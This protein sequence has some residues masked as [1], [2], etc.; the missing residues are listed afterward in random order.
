M[1]LMHIIVLAVIQGLTEFLPISSTAHLV[2]IPYFAN[3]QD[4]GLQMDIALH[5]GSL[6]ALILYFHKEV[7][8]L[9]KGFFDLLRFKITPNS[10]LFLFLVIATIPAAIVGYFI[11]SSQTALLRSVELIGWMTIIFGILLGAVDRF[12][13]RLKTLKDMT[14]LQS[15]LIGCAQVVALFPGVSRSGITMTAG[16]FM[17]YT[18]VECARFSFLVAMPTIFGASLLDFK[19]IL[20]EA[21]Y[22]FQIDALIGVCF[23]FI[24]SLIAIAFMIKWLS[25]YS[26]IPFV[27]YR[28]LLGIGLLS[29]AY[30]FAA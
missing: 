16:R 11:F 24:S 2:L 27:V 30:G 12:A 1:E 28:L 7:I 10:K 19:D 17:G 8:L 26:F 23:S 3:W 9:F 20:H 25:K 22:D 14:Y 4:Q 29:Y 13:P 21:N 6:L 18:R 15:F 5:F